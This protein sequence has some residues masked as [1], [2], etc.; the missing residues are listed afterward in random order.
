[1]LYKVSQDVKVQ[2]LIFAWRIVQYRG[3]Q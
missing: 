1:M 3:C 2:N